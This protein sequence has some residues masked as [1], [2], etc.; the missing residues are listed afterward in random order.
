M[1]LVA[2]AI[3]KLNIGTA[4]QTISAAVGSPLNALILGIHQEV[5]DR[6]LVSIVKHDAV[7]SNRLKQSIVSADVSIPGK[8]ILEMSAEF[9]WKYVNFGV[10]G[11][12]V[13]HGSP[14]WG[15]APA[16]AVSF[17]ENI[18][19]WIQDRG[20]TANPG[21]TYDQMAFVIM[22]WIRLNGL[23]PRP[24]FTDVVNKQL[25]QYINKTISLV[26]KKALIIEIKTPS[27]QAR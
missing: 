19:K 23:K 21:Q 4:K 8:V 12:A 18:L 2:D 24:F 9:Y 26:Y 10:N 14:T 5:I 1:G 3:S 17:K 20:I 16:G 27:W 7:A 11:T 25:T 15:P 22:R 6:L 13:S